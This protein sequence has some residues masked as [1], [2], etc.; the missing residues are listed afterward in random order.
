MK[1]VTMTVPELVLFYSD[2]ESLWFHR[3]LWHCFSHSILSHH[4][5][6][7]RQYEEGNAILHSSTF[8]FSTVMLI[9]CSKY[10]YFVRYYIRNALRSHFLEFWMFCQDFGRN[11][12]NSAHHDPWTCLMHDMRRI[13]RCTPSSGTPPKKK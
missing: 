6:F 3:W 5:S 13:F 7:L 2:G 1:K 4:V 10:W 12:V 11:I 8:P 9:F